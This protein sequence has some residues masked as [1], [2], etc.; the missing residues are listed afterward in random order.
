MANSRPNPEVPPITTATRPVKSIRFLA[1][2]ESP[3]STVL[4][5]MLQ[6]V[7]ASCA[8]RSG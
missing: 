5:D 2:I 8:R 4:W 6:L 1:A 7:K 3:K